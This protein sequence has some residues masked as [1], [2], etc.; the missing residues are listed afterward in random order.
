[1]GTATTTDPTISSE[2]VRAATEWQGVVTV[3][4]AGLST[5][6]HTAGRLMSGCGHLPFG[7]S[8]VF[9]LGG[10]KSGQ[11]TACNVETTNKEI[12]INREHCNLGNK[13]RGRKH[14]SS[15]WILRLVDTILGFPSVGIKVGHSP[16]LVDRQSC[17]GCSYLLSYIPMALIYLLLV[18]FFPYFLLWESRW[19]VYV[20]SVPSAIISLRGPQLS[21]DSWS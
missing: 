4:S 12:Q 17:M 9:P 14:I 7:P 11:K 6:W 15:Y 3:G 2:T 8:F 20:S 13:E 10:A 21:F 1:M 16:R 18:F 19:A 5:Q